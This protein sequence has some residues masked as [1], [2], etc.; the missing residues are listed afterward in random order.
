MAAGGISRRRELTA[1]GAGV[2]GAVAVGTVGVLSRD[3]VADQTPGSNAG[4]AVP[5]YGEHQAGISTPAQDRLHFVT[6]DVTTD[7]R[8]DLVDL[9]R[10][11]TRAATRMAAGHDAGPVGAV[12]GLPDAPPDD[13]GEAMGLP[14]SGLTLTVGFGP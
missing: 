4:D 11:W 7:S 3:A 14:A 9:L 8:A 5:F 6:F 12:A 13:T 10:E 1:G 2:A